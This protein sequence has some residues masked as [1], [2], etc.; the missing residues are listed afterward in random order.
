VFAVP[1]SPLTGK[2]R[3]SNRLLKEGA[4][5]VEC[6][7][8]VIEELAPQMIGPLASRVAVAADRPSG[9][10]AKPASTSANPEA[11]ADAPHSV[12]LRETDKPVETALDGFT[13]ILSNQKGLKDSML[14]R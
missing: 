7:E 3:G 14:T 13:T 6:V 12:P 9:V 4:K 2:T 11:R 1:G 8:D 5:L 10:D